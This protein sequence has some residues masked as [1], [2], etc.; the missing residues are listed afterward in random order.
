MKEKWISYNIFHVQNTAK[1]VFFNSTIKQR[2]KEKN[3]KE[4]IES[5]AE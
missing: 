4:R 5:Y 1:S 2:H 3:E